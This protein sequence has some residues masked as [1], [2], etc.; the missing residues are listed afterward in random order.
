M[1]STS[2]VRISTVVDLARGEDALKCL[3]ATF[4]L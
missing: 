2:E 1:I 4:G 3:T